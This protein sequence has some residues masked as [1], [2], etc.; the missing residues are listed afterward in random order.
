MPRSPKKILEEQEIKSIIHLPIYIKSEFYGYIGLDEC[1][2]ERIW[3][4]EEVSFLKTL[5]S[6][7]EVAIERKEN[8]DSLQSLNQE[9]KKSNQELAMSNKELEQFAYVASHDLQEPLR[10]NTSFLTLIEKK[11]APHLDEKGRQYI[12]FAVDGA[13][14]LKTIILDLLEYSRVGKVQIPSEEVDVNLMLE[15]LQSLLQTNIEENN[16]RLIWSDLPKI[17]IQ[18]PYLWQLLQ[19]IISNAIKYRRE[20]VDPEIEVSVIEEAKNWHF[21]IKDNGLGIPQE[22]HK[23]IFI[24]FQRLHGK[25]KYSGTGIGLAI[26]KKIVDNLGGRIWVESQIDKGS[27][28]HFSLPKKN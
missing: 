18:K 13:L 7:F 3:T 2:R 25:E 12:H 23:K 4:E 16:A 20:E 8:L 9:L 1:K 14:R 28:F 24:I 17:K 11:Y 21:I 5:V 27:T 10:M 26:C 15:E 22:Y 19:N 6:N